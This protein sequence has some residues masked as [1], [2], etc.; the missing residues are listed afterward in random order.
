MVLRTLSKAFALA[1]SRCGFALANT[2]V[3]TVMRKVLAPYPLPDLTIQVA[4]QAL[5]APALQRLHQQINAI[6]E[7]RDWLLRQLQRLPVSLVAQPDTNFILV[8]VDN[9]D[10]LMTAVAADGILLRNQSSQPGL[11]NCIR[12]TVGSAQ[13]NQQLIRCLS[14]YLGVES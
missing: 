6:I 5:A 3:L 14:R 8:A 11:D 7:Q 9:A 10:S 13:E 12:I 2:D 1:G 4:V